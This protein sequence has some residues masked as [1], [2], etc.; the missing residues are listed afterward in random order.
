MENTAN[1][2]AMQIPSDSA[3]FMV[4]AMYAP[5]P[6][7][8]EQELDED[9]RRIRAHHF[10]VIRAFIHWEH[11]E[12]TEGSFDFT[13][14]D[15]LYAAAARHGVS[16]AQTIGLYPPAWMTTRLRSLGLYSK[17]RYQCLDIPEF[18]EPCSRFIQAAVRRY[19]DH[20]VQGM[21]F[22][23][24]EPV[25]APC[26]C[27]HTTEKFRRWLCERHGSTEVLRERWGRRHHIFS[28]V[29]APG[30]WD[31]LDLS[32]EKE[33]FYSDKRNY[34]FTQEW[35]DFAQD[36]LAENVRWVSD[37]IRAID[38]RHP[39]HTNPCTLLEN[40]TSFGA[41]PWRIGAA[42]DSLGVSAHPC[43][44]FVRHLD[45]IDPIEFAAETAY[46][47]LIDLTA[48]AARGKDFWVSELQAGANLNSG[49]RSFSPT[50]LNI[51]AWMLHAAARGARGLL[52]WL[53]R[54]WPS[55]WEAGEFSLVNAATGAD[56]DRSRA[57][58]EAARLL[59][60]QAALLSGLHPEPARVAILYSPDSLALA[61]REHTPRDWPV[62]ASF[63]C[64]RALWKHNI[65]VDFITPAE[66][67]SG[68]LEERGIRVLY[69]PHSKVMADSTGQA[70]ARFV[71]AGG[72]LWADGH[73]AQRDPHSHLHD[74]APGAGLA[75]VFGC[76]E[77]DLTVPRAPFALR[78]DDGRADC[79]GHRFQQS[80]LTDA[81]TARVAAR[82][83]DGKAAIVA[84]THGRGHALFVGTYLSIGYQRNEDPAA[85]RLIVDFALLHG[86]TPRA[87]IEP[88][89]N[90]AAPSVELSVL[91][92][93]SR[94][95]IA[96]TNRGNATAR[97]RLRGH[98][99][100]TDLATNLTSEVVTLLPGDSALLLSNQ[101]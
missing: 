54:G 34:A 4:G 26:T 73:C 96:A 55:A 93:T 84:N 3:A 70:I 89:D 23:W 67:E 51:K 66:I 50:P 12:A 88:V 56:T 18:H 37:Q 83:E 32:R 58:A 20:P 87:V 101:T 53:W 92:N 38:T 75:T 19:A 80:L 49:Q 31:D 47:Y 16:I 77:E 13:V 99:T 81:S 11:A 85:E 41:D 39:V 28:S 72:A 22:V 2:Q 63:G 68:L 14:H 76:H 30:T 100:L 1:L 6:R 21:W 45:T 24:N 33:T 90:A 65:A 71:D 44:H 9:L 36:N 15:R 91:G 78:F 98:T 86:A 43:H 62:L 64:Y 7:A 29:H 25:K 95:I 5:S 52:F 97:F 57:A 27:V 69:L 94:H 46:P 8:T 35:L 40:G 42:V 60:S 82:F 61:M 59:A 17:D 79:P 74:A 48:S 10:T